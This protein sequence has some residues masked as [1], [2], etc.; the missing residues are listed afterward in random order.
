M[1]E[2]LKKLN[3]VVIFDLEATCDDKSFVFDFENETIEIGAVKI[4]DNTIVGEF[5]TFIKPRDT[6]I[7]PF[8]TE[9]TTI[10]DADITDASDFLTATQG[11][12]QF[13]GNA[14][15]LSWGDYDRKQLLKDFE[16]HGATPPFWLK[17]HINFKKEFAIYKKIQP[18]G[19]KKALALCNIPLE[20]TH[21][22]GIDDAR[23]I[24][25]IYLQVKSELDP[26]WKIKMKRKSK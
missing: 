16:R 21:H 6:L 18:C 5:S 14:R 26:F 11:F 20:G 7:T 22:R 10:T 3:E 4:K 12:D 2:I 23:N 17:R 1:T 24:A 19:M 13:I 15:I 8:C 25:K 9:L